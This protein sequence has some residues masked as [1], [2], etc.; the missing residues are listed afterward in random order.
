MI[1][2][3]PG[4]ISDVEAILRVRYAAVHGP[5]TSAFY[6]QEMLQSWSPSPIDECRANNLRQAIQNCKELVVIA[7]SKENDTV[8]G[9]GS[10]IPDQN[11]LGKLYIDPS[12]A[13]QGIGTKI[14]ANLEELAIFHGLDKLHLDSSL[15]AEKFYSHHGYLVVHRSTCRLNSGIDLE[16]VQMS[17]QL[18][19]N[20]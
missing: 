13:C 20:F 15:N 8:V 5:A 6:T 17:K 10:I 18:R 3:R 11:K 4:T 14:L 1:E 7:V 12:F 16:C 2:L 19:I 9:F